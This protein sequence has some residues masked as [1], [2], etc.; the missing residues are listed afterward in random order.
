MEHLSGFGLVDL[1]YVL[2][3]GLSMIIYHEESVD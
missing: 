2:D 1:V 3:T